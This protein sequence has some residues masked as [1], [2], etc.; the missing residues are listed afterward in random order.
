[1]YDMM[2]ASGKMSPEYSY[3]NYQASY[4]KNSRAIGV[5]WCVFSMCY[6]IINVVVFLQVSF[7]PQSLGH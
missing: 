2:P 4:L 3:F 6:A 1:M 5:L 7:G